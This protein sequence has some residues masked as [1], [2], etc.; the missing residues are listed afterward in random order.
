MP[1]RIEA[2]LKRWPIKVLVLVAAVGFSTYCIMDFASMARNRHTQAI[3]GEMNTIME[4][5]QK[6]PPGIP[7]AEQLLHKVRAIDP[8][9]APAEVKQAL[10]DYGDALEGSLDAM[11]TGRD[12]TQYD[13]RMAD[14]KQRLAVCFRKYR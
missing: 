11:K 5:I 13:L 14:A 10:R 9:L 6:L 1:N 4:D 12:T 8:G 3:L 2:L 7:R